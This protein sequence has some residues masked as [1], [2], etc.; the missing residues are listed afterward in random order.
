MY[1]VIEKDPKV[2]P[3]MSGVVGHRE[4]IVQGIT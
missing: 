1:E 4:C 3:S 2:V